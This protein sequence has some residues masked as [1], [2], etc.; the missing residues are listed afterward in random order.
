MH[1][2]IPL[3]ASGKS[4][5]APETSVLANVPPII[6]TTSPTK[7]INI[8]PTAPDAWDSTG[9]HFELMLLMFTNGVVG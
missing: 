7:G 8:V 2:Q 4:D 9:G 6:A 3:S 1:V 5:L